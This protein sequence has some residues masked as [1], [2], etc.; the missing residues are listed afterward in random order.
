[1][2]EKE[3]KEKTNYI[4]TVFQLDVSTLHPNLSTLLSF[5]L[6][7]TDETK[8]GDPKL[9]NDIFVLRRFHMLHRR[10]MT[11]ITVFLTLS[12]PD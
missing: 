11:M 7:Y 10:A 8:E 9:P 1:L 6:R 12:F 5:V 3:R 4:V 2:R